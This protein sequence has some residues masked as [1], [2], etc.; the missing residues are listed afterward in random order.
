MTP[1]KEKQ[2]LRPIK[3]STASM[4]PHSTLSEKF[5]RFYYEHFEVAGSCSY[6][7]HPIPSASP[8]RDKDL[9]SDSLPFVEDSFPINPSLNKTNPLSGYINCISDLQERC[10]TLERKLELVDFHQLMLKAQTS[11]YPLENGENKQSTPLV[12]VAKLSEEEWNYFKLRMYFHK[13]K[14]LYSLVQDLRCLIFGKAKASIEEKQIFISAYLQDLH[15]YLSATIGLR[16][17]G[18]S[19]VMDKEFDDSKLCRTIKELIQYQQGIKKMLCNCNRNFTISRVCLDLQ[20][21]L[22]ISLPF[23]NE[24]LILTPELLLDYGLVHQIIC[25]DPSKASKFGRK[26]ALGLTQGFKMNKKFVDAI[27]IS[28][29]PEWVSNGSLIPAQH[30]VSFHY[31]NRRPTRLFCP[32]QFFDICVEP[33]INQIKHWRARIISRDFEAYLKNMGYLIAANPFHQIFYSKKSDPLPT[34]SVTEDI[35][36]L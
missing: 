1:K 13:K 4:K 25:S 9:S 5:M 18:L 36:L 24:E 19:L 20:Y 16:V 33:L 12:D 31:Q 35:K 14:K 8:S 32:L 6:S 23:K 26:I 11:F 30:I 34:K 10:Q 2:P 17:P 3:K 27:I 28:K 21:Y 7:K 22:P 15:I 29:A